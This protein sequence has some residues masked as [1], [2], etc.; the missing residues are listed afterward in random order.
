MFLGK[1]KKMKCPAAKNAIVAVVQGG[2]NDPR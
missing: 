2:A 1:V